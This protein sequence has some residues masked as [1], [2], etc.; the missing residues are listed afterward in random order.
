MMDISE[1]NNTKACSVDSYSLKY[2]QQNTTKMDTGLYT[3]NV[4]S[5]SIFYAMINFVLTRPEVYSSATV[6][7]E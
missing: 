1:W 6:K 7:L 5:V 2:S 4:K 3:S